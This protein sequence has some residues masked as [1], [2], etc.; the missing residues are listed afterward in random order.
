[1]CTLEP[2]KNLVGVIRAFRIIIDRGL[3]CRLVIVGAKGWQ[4][5]PVFDE[6]SRLHLETRVR[7]LGYVPD[8]DLPGLY[9]ACEAFLYL[10]LYEGFGLPP[11]EAMACGS[12]IIVSDRSSMPEVIGDAGLLCDPTSP[13]D[14]AAKTLTVLGD[15]VETACWRERALARARHFSWEKTARLT[16]DVYTRVLAA[17]RA[18]VSVAAPITR[19]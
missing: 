11:L 16:H 3:A 14:I 8:D 10:S 17:R 15:A 1:V 9:S 4:F 7:F 18:W 19:T 12:P 6:V 13:E 2:R 5:S